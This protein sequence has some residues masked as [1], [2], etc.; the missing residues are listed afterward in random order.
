[1]PYVRIGNPHK[2]KPVCIDC[3][4]FLLPVGS[5]TQLQTSRSV[6]TKDT[7]CPYPRKIINKINGF[8]SDFGDGKGTERYYDDEIYSEKDHDGVAP[9][10][11]GH[12]I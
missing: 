5:N 7:E 6:K 9:G 3:A 1:M 2:D 10:V 11:T 8:D 4:I 12:A